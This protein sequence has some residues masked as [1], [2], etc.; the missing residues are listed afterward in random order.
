MG[1]KEYYNLLAAYYETATT[2]PRAWLPNIYALNR[3]KVLLKERP[4]SALD[5]GAGTGQTAELIRHLYPDI[6]L[7]AVDFSESMLEILRTKKLN[8]KIV[9][10]DI[11]D[12]VNISSQKWHLIAAIGSLEFIPHL[13]R[14]LSLIHRKL[15]MPGGTFVF[16]Y[17]P[18]IFGYAGQDKKI[19][20]ERA[21]SSFGN[22]TIT[23]FRYKPQSI[24]HAL[25]KCKAII[26]ADEEFVAYNKGEKAVV[27]HLIII[28]KE[29]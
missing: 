7:T 28:K 12:F 5:L 6:P 11:T 10:S 3:L 19:T 16:T 9:E 23:T 18:I 2:K 14:L 1:N 13:P 26:K 29:A 15:L 17:E 27:Y 8:L 4:E 21:G 24:A 20:I 25:L 22:E